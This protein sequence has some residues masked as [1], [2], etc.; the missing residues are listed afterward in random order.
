VIV[1]AIRW[2]L[3]YNL[4]YRDV[5]VLLLERG[6]EVDHVT[7]FRRVQRFTR[8]WSTPRGSPAT[9]PVTGG[10]STRRQRRLALRVPGD[11][12]AWPGHRRAG[13]GPPR[14]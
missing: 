6:I 3:Q 12:P 10:S 5:E 11:R 14:R 13:L 8:F 9:R 7:V 1:V 4:S 2:Y